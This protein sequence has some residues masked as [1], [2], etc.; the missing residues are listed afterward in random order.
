MSTI[1]LC[2][3]VKNEARRLRTCLDSY[4]PIADEIIIVDTGSSDNTVEI[5][6][7]YTD[8][9]YSFPWSDDFS[10]A[11]NYAFSLCTCDFI[12]SAD[13][14]EVLDQD[15]LVKFQSLKE[16]IHPEVDIVTMKYINVNGIKSVYNSTSELRPKLFRR[17]R[18]WTFISPIHETVRL[19]PLT[20]DSDICILHIQESEHNHRDFSIYLKALD[21]GNKLEK[22]VVRMLCEQLYKTA[23]FDDLTKLLPYFDKYIIPEYGTVDDLAMPILIAMLRITRVLNLTNRFY[24]YSVNS[25]LE[26]A[27]CISSEICIEIGSYQEALK[28]YDEA[29]FWYIKASNSDCCLDIVSSGETAF[30]SAARILHM[31]GQDQKAKE[32][33]D[34]ANDWQL[35]EIL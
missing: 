10:K 26:C 14:D 18:T 30:L 13:A 19:T 29:L 17:L 34:L 23:D 5:A 28:N 3:I 9:V 27:S 24:T 6:N 8:H 11:R 1:S 20:Y 12:Y 2:M 32:Y 35:P 22:Y 21:S 15:N 7:E 16:N 33:E 25:V 31:L 4:L